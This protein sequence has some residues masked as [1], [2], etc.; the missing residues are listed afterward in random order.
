V[1]L[2]EPVDHRFLWVT[3]HPASPVKVC[4]IRDDKGRPA[5]GSFEYLI[6]PGHPVSYHSI[7]IF[8]IAEGNQR[9]GQAILILFIS[10]CNLIIW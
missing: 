6:G 7:V 1:A 5:S 8:P 10:E 2:A 9:P 4:G 3:A